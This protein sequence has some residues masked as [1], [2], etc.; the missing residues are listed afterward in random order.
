MAT[1]KKI[2]ITE[3]EKEVEGD[4]ITKV[5]TEFGT[6]GHVIVPKKYVGKEANVI[7]PTDQKLKWRLTYGEL[8]EFI[9]GCLKTLEGKEGQTAFYRRK[10][11][12][13]V[14][15]DSFSEDDLE[16]AI[17]VLKMSGDKGH[18]MLVQKVQ[19]VYNL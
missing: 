14:R 7:I 6:S 18:K 10:S 2:K 17:D 12:M 16:K 5:I 3:N 4:V 9:D 19:E 1:T 8:R 13:N 11:I 15:S